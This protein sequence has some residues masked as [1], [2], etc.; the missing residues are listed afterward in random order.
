MRKK[1]GC[2]N[3]STKKKKKQE[4]KME[5]ENNRKLYFC[6]RKELCKCYYSNRIY[7]KG[8]NLLN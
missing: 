2:I 7:G 1:D 3:G 8:E 4:Q 6:E 5:K